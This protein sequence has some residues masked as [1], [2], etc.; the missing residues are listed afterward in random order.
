[1]LT[2]LNNAVSS[3]LYD[4][5]TSVAETTLENYRW[6]LEQFSKYEPEEGKSFGARHIQKFSGK[7]ITAFLIYL[8]EVRE[9]SQNSIHDAWASIR[10]FWSWAVRE[11]EISHPMANLKAPKP[12][13]VPIETYS[14]EQLKAL[15]LACETTKAWSRWGKTELCR[16]GSLRCATKR[17]SRC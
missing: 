17:S 1:M 8:R 15:L 2:S 9:L 13:E 12:E 11:Y 10:A 4:K 6:W 5:K 7:D 16:S 14:H 3:Y